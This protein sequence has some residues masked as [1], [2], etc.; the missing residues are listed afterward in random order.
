[1]WDNWIVSLL[2]FSTS[3]YS[4]PSWLTIT[5]PIV[6][7][8]TIIRLNIIIKM[9]KWS[10]HWN[11]STDQWMKSNL[12]VNYILIF[13]YKLSNH[14][15]SIIQINNLYF[16][17]RWYVLVNYCK[18]YFFKHN[19]NLYNWWEINYCIKIYK[20]WKHTRFIVLSRYKSHSYTHININ[21]NV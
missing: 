16:R 11:L 2:P 18:G 4:N 15:L 9:S 14:L 10:F 13:I 8:I 5:I 17:C 6:K 21:I 3:K 19:N 20:H 1:M 7:P 12:W